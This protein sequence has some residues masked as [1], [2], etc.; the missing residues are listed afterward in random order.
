ML[1]YTNFNIFRTHKKNMKNL[2]K[3]LSDPAKAKRGRRINL[4][5]QITILSWLVEFLSFFIIFLGAYILGNKNSKVTLGMQTLTAFCYLIVVPSMYLLNTNKFK[6]VILE[7][8]IYSAF[9][10]LS[11]IRLP[12]NETQKEQDD[13]QNEDDHNRLPNAENDRETR[14]GSEE[15][16]YSGD[17]NNRDD[18]DFNEDGKPSNE[19]ACE[20]L[21]KPVEAETTDNAEEFQDTAITRK[22]C[23]MIDLEHEQ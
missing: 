11:L 4:N 22:K 21:S 17:G 13:D 2:K 9:S 1:Y 20:E 19:V 3:L 12:A 6:A 8:K 14:H 16:D 15:N 18:N 23:V 7:S 5:I 10:Y